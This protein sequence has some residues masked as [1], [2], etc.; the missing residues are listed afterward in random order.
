M[1]VHQFLSG[2]GPYDAVSNEALA[3]RD[4]FDEWGWGGADWT[5]E[6]APGTDGRLRPLHDF[7]GAGPG[8]LLLIRYSA[9]APMLREL[10]ELP[11]R[12]VLKYH[13]IT[14]AKW[15]WAFE[16]GA[17]VQCAVGRR[18]LPEFASGVELAAADSSYN[19]AELRAAGAPATV[20]L[21][22]LFDRA[23]LGDPRPDAPARPARPTTLLFV[24]R[25]VPS[26]RQDELIR[27]VALLRRNAEPDARLVLVGNA[28]N[29]TY[30]AHLQA[31]ADELAPGSVEIVSGASPAALAQRYRE[32][33]VFVCLSEH[34]GFCVPVLEAYHHGV[35]VVARPSGGLPE[36][37]GDGTLL[38]GDRDLA[39]V[40]E[41]VALA[42]RDEGLRSDLHARAQRRLDELSFDRTAARVRAALEPLGG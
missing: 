38:V 5:A 22:I 29:P 2:A 42:A 18:Q 25:I 41:L 11:N 26:K 35:P 19:A 4:L 31:F 37:A 20:V 3:Y 36:T 9:Y 10:L 32:A 21:P 27:T 14:P 40:A 7:A 30:R 13:N 33:T 34:E 28:L 15:F 17:G 1:I 23:R 24:G 8:D 6:A 39:V 12:K 16:P